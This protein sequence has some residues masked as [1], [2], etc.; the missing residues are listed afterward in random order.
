MNY[1]DGS[2]SE[3]ATIR[4]D[5]TV[6]RARSVEDSRYVFSGT[7]IVVDE[8]AWERETTLTLAE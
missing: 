3:G 2:L 1:T 4:T 6:T 5:D 7:D 8:R